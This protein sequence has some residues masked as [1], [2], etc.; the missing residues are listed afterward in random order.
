MLVDYK[1][2][3]EYNRIRKSHPTN[4][5]EGKFELNWGR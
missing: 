2:S 3:A 5:R 1:T 4:K